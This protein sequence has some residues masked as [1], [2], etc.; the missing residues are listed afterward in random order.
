[1]GRLP[2]DPHASGH[3]L[4]TL[5]GQLQRQSS[6]RYL[7]LKFDF[8]SA[9]VRV[10]V[11]ILMLLFAPARPITM[12]EKYKGSR[13]IPSGEK[14]IFITQAICPVP[15]HLRNTGLWVTCVFPPSATTRSFPQLGG[16]RKHRVKTVANVVGAGH[17][18]AYTN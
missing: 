5:S 9:V 18:V 6:R 1:M 13:L 11:P 12:D 8:L 15:H 14:D 4:G 2:M 3:P 7:L 17:D 16:V 10:E